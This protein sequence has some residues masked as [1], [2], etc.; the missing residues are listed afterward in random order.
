MVVVV[1]V[2]AHVTRNMCF[3]SRGLLG[4]FLS[5][6]LSLWARVGAL[7]AERERES[8]ASSS[9]DT[10]ILRP[11]AL[12]CGR[13]CWPPH[14]LVVHPIADFIADHS[15]SLY[16]QEDHIHAARCREITVLSARG[17]RIRLATFA[18]LDSITYTKVTTCRDPGRREDR[19]AAGLIG[20]TSGGWT[21]RALAVECSA[22][23][24]PFSLC[25]PVGEL[26]DLCQAVC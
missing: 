8:Q 4:L 2:A 17:R 16:R 5:V 1:V 14:Q 3:D 22:W 11:R 21:V 20:A 15:L 26:S 24:D 25:V 13:I 7:Q 9:V 12:R 6:F 19:C 18:C 10:G 23:L